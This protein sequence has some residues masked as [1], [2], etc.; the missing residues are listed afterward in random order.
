MSKTIPL[1]KG[2]FA[3]VDDEDFDDLNQFKWHAVTIHRS[4]YARR[5]IFKDGVRSKEF[6]HVRIMGI[7]SRLVDHRDRDGLNNTRSNLR[8][9]THQQNMQNRSID[10]RNK[11]GVSGVSWNKAMSMWRVFV[12]RAYIGR[13]LNF[14]DAVAARKSAE[15]RIFGEYAPT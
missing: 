7:S 3:T 11:T 9:V 2:L 12:G 6:M 10:R 1:N 4:T 13:F 14:D 5:C 15:Q 8:Q